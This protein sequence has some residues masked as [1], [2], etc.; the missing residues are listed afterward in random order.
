M[1]AHLEPSSFLIKVHYVP[2]A[3][4]LPLSFQQQQFSYFIHRYKLWHFQV[5]QQKR[6]RGERAQVQKKK[7]CVTRYALLNNGE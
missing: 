7:N 1:E 6:R 4:L 2:L 3:L 5:E